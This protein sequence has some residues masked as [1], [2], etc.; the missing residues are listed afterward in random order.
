MDLLDFI[1][2]FFGL[3]ILLVGSI[4][5]GRSTVRNQ[6]HVEQKEL[7]NTLTLSNKVQKDQILDLQAK[8]IESVRSVSKLQGQI[9]IIKDIPLKKI[10]E[11]MT[12]IS[13]EM[14]KMSQNQADIVEI[15]KA[16]GFIKASD[17]TSHD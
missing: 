8:H 7:I 13:G 12:A 3:V 14:L 11:D 4:V 6:N 15:L 16:N 17:I 10:S 5:V 2:A 9:D 1:L